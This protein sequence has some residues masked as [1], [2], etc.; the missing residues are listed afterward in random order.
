VDITGEGVGEEQA[1]KR[2]IQIKVQRLDFRLVIKE[3]S[4]F[5]G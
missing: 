3:G 2:V 1:V 5:M 4:V